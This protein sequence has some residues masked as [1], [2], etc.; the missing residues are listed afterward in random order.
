MSRPLVGMSLERLATN[1][2]EP[3][4]FLAGDMFPIGAVSSFYGHGGTGKTMAMLDLML[5]AALALDPEERRWFGRTVR[6]AVSLGLF[7]EEA[8]N[9]LGS[10]LIALSDGREARGAL[11]YLDHA[12]RVIP[13]LNDGYGAEPLWR[14]DSEGDLIAS[15]LWGRITETAAEMLPRHADE[16]P[17]LI[18]LDAASSFFGGDELKRDHARAFLAELNRAAAEWDAAIILIAHPSQE[19]IK[20]GGYSGSTGWWNH[21][22]QL[23]TMEP[24]PRLK[25]D[26]DHISRSVVTIRKNN[27]GP[28]GRVTHHLFD[29]QAFSMAEPPAPKVK[30]SARQ[31]VG[32]AALRRAIATAPAENRDGENATTVEAWRAAAYDMG[33]SHSDQPAAKR[34]AFKRL[35]DEMEGAD[36]IEIDE[37]FVWLRDERDKA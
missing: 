9:E 11:N 17:M 7:A 12:M 23:V 18:V 32:V 4:R 1:P 29:G 6:P 22:R 21:T 16:A 13:M 20:S 3:R 27:Y 8:G 34:Q 24:A 31:K 14:R 10:R 36:L 5:A 15:D 25:A 2:P 35:R 19:G 28:V 37:P 33:V 30:V 26:P